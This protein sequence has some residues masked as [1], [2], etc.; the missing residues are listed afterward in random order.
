[1]IVGWVPARRAMLGALNHLLP[2]AGSYRAQLCGLPVPQGELGLA[3]MVLS[4]DLEG[5]LA[6]AWRCYHHGSLWCR[7]WPEAGQSAFHQAHSGERAGGQGQ[8][9][10]GGRPHPEGMGALGCRALTGSLICP[11]LEGSSLAG[12]THCQGPA[13]AV[14]EPV[15]PVPA[16]CPSPPAVPGTLQG[17]SG[18][19]S[20]LPGLVACPAGTVELC[21]SYCPHSVW[22][23]TVCLCPHWMTVLGVCQIKQCLKYLGK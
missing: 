9:L 20:L 19:S 5:G 6:S 22:S 10:A 2:S 3:R 1:M 11:S 8:L 4:G 15:L 13:M 14:L 21:P 16:P 23:P 12:V 7:V 18:P 17:L